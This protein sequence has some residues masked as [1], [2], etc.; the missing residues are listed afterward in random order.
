MHQGGSDTPI[1]YKDTQ[2]YFRGNR[3]VKAHFK[4]LITKYKMDYAS[5][6]MLTGGSAGGI[7]S[8]MW[9]NYLQSIVSNP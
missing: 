8:F 6:I 9:G 5:K 1:Q 2:L 7:A 3:I 4:Y